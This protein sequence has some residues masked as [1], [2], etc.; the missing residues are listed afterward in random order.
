MKRLLKLTIL[1]FSITTFSQQMTMNEWDELAKSNTRLLPKYG[2]IP[3]TEDEKK[4]DALFIEE[5]LQ[6]EK[7]NGDRTAASNNMIRL[8]FNYLYRGDLKTAMYRF[9]Q[10]YLLDSLN[11]D[12]Y[13]GYGAVYMQLKKYE[14]A[15]E[16]YEEGLTQN[17]NNTHLL[18]DYG[19]Y[20]M[21]HYY[22]LNA[23]DEK[24][25]SSHLDIAITYLLKSHQ[26]DKTDQNTTFKLSICNWIKGNCKKAWEYYDKCM[27]FGGKPITEAYTNDLQKKCGRKKK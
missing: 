13:W 12:I 18:T 14:K 15:K 16:M 1:L 5:T 22:L 9:N 2:D 6:L 20:Y 23:R 19:T 11:T 8:G 24:L 7:F 21:N 3:K 17:P 25:A 10:A 4:S 27:D 26:L